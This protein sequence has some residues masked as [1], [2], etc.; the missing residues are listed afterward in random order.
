M[1][2]K[3]IMRA[4]AEGYQ[5]YLHLKGLGLRNDAADTLRSVRR[6][7]RIHDTALACEKSQ[8]ELPPMPDELRPSS[9]VRVQDQ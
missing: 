3:Q 2:S 8:Q 4:W 5:F 9:R 7:A 6:L 1:D